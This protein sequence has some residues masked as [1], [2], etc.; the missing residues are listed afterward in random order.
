MLDVCHMLK[1]VR[2]TLGDKEIFYAANGREI[3]WN[4]MKEL[5]NV[6]KNDILHLGNKL[7]S[8]YIKY[9]NQKMKVAIAAQTLS[10]SAATGIKYLLSLKLK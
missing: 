9:N 7:K 8:K 5:Y 4:Y 3:R 6:Q 1:L 2:N 10:Y